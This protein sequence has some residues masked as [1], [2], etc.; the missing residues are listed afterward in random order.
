MYSYMSKKRKKELKRFWGANGENPLSGRSVKVTRGK[1][2][3][4]RPPAGTQENPLYFPYEKKSQ[5]PKGPRKSQEPLNKY[6][7][8]HAFPVMEIEWKKK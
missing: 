5:D 1:R 4:E 6:P 3:R 8:K 7:K 2:E